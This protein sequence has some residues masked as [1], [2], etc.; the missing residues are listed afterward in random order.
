MK[1][2]PTSLLSKV[3]NEAVDAYLVDGVTS[4]LLFKTELA[5]AALRIENAKNT[6]ANG[7]D[8]P[9]HWHWDWRKKSAKIDWLAYR[10]FGIECDSAMQGLMLVNTINS[11][12]LQDQKGKP[13][14]YI[15]YIESAPW[16]AKEFHPTPYY[17]GV[18]VRLIEASIRFSLSEGF[19][20]RVGLHSLPQSEQFY[21]KT[22]GMTRGEI[23][24]RYEGLRWFELTTTNA[25]KF[26]GDKP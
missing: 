23:D 18:G 8:V 21:E 12:R 1:R 7:G 10:C 4:D 2:I 25:K 26:L 20:G 14:V 11:S 19:G 17:G 15:D 22:C 13:L 6:H 9:E 3:T 5:W 24:L 16:N